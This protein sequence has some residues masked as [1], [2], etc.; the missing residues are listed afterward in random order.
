MESGLTALAPSRTYPTPFVAWP[1]SYFWQPECTTG[2]RTETVSGNPQPSNSPDLLPAGMYIPDEEFEADPEGMGFLAASIFLGYWPWVTMSDLWPDQPPLMTCT[3]DDIGPNWAAFTSTA[4]YT[5]HSTMYTTGTT[6][7][8]AI[9]KPTSSS[10]P[11]ETSKTT[12]STGAHETTG[13]GDGNSSGSSVTSS[14]QVIVSKV[15]TVVVETVDGKETKIPS[16][17]DV[18]ISAVA[19]TPAG[20]GADNEISV[21]NSPEGVT[22]VVPITTVKSTTIDGKL[23]SY[24][25]SYFITLTM[26]QQGGASH[27]SSTTLIAVPTELVTTLNGTPTSLSTT[28]LVVSTI[29]SRDPITIVGVPIPTVVSTVVDG[30]PT[31]YSTT[32]YGTSVEYPDGTPSRAAS[33]ITTV[34]D[35][36]TM[37]VT[38]IDGTRTSISTTLPVTTTI[39]EQSAGVQQTSEA[40][41]SSSPNS[42]A[43]GCE[44]RSTVQLGLTAFV[45]FLTWVWSQ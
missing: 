44:K 33:S 14:V 17:Y 19:A 35:V 8:S 25:T 18:T 38:T 43:G 42:A 45:A 13:Q 11:T 16:Q 36:P 6:T 30:T 4:W 26:P 10:Q 37:L 1:S 5:V 23:T 12:S 2:L 29:T 32:I 28:L 39:A 7:E 40:S 24:S 21:P 3:D 22:T 41:S 31:S 27:D 15:S 34:L 9:P 20:S